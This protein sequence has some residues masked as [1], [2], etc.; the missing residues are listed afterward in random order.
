VET[1]LGLND[2]LD[3]EPVHP[4]DDNENAGLNPAFFI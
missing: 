2:L 1:G 3:G 4:L